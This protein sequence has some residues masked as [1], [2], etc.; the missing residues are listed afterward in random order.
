M[1][2]AISVLALLVM[3]VGACCSVCAYGEEKT[4]TLSKKG[5]YRFLDSN[6]EQKLREMGKAI[7]TAS[8]ENQDLRAALATLGIDPT[9]EELAVASEIMYFLTFVI[10]SMNGEKLDR[11]ILTDSERMVF[12]K[13]MEIFR[14]LLEKPVDYLP[15][16]QTVSKYSGALEDQEIGEDVENYIG[17]LLVLENARNGMPGF[18]AE[19]FLLLFTMYSLLE[20]MV[21]DNESPEAGPEVISDEDAMASL[22]TIWI[23]HELKKLGAV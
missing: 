22:N 13:L 3:L 21:F 12:R 7:V 5:T 8:L 17:K 11:E 20:D 9:E 15:L 2:R 1:K 14:I 4:D 18:T 19:D 10:K 16:L 23:A 6:D